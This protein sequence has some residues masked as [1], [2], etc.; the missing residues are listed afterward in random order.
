MGQPVAEES[1]GNELGLSATALAALSTMSAQGAI[2]PLKI[3]SAEWK[4][5]VMLKLPCSCRPWQLHER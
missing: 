3:V 1:F 2:S 4:A 5:A